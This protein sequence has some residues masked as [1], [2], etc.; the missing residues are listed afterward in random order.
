M[1]FGIMVPQLQRV[2]VG[3]TARQHHLIVGQGTTGRRHLDRLTNHMRRVRGKAH[4]HLGITRNRPRGT[5]QYGL[6]GVERGSSGHSF[7]GAESLRLAHH[8]F[9]QVLAEHALII[10]GD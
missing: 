7:S 9:G 6:E 4:L 10:F 3:K 5:G 8:A 1:Q 2:G